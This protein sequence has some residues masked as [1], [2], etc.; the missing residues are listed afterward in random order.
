MKRA[1][2]DTLTTDQLFERFAEIS[3]G[4]YEA[5]LYDEYKKLKRL[6]GDMRAVDDELRKRGRNARLDLLRLYDHPNMQV[7][8]HAAKCTLGV[9]PDAARRVIEAVRASG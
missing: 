6:F 8:L 7:R 2:I 1:T 5:L 3:V 4:Q 9:A